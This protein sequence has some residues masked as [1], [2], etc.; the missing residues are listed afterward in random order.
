M[1]SV[2]LLTVRTSCLKHICWHFVLILE[3]EDPFSVSSHSGEASCNWC[4]HPGITEG[5]GSNARKFPIL[6][7]EPAART[8]QQ[9]IR[10]GRAVVDLLGRQKDPHING[11]TGI[12]PL[13][14]C[15]K[16]NIVDGMILDSLHWA[17]FGIGRR[18]MKLWLGETKK[19]K[20]KEN[21][22]AR[23]NVQ[24]P[25]YYVGTD[26]TKAVIDR[27][28]VNF[29][30]P[31]E[32]RRMPRELSQLH[33]FNAREFENIILYFSV[34]MF[35]GILPE[36]YMKHWILFVQAFYLL[37]KDKVTKDEVEVARE[38]LKRYVSKIG[39]LYGETEL[40]FN[41]HITLHA[42]DNTLRWSSFW[43]IS[44]FA[45]ENGNK[46]IKTKIHGERGIP[47]QVIRSLNRDSA[48]G[49]LRNVASTPQTSRFRRRMKRKEISKSFYAGTV[50]CVRPTRFDPTEDEQWLCD[51]KGID[52]AEY[53]QCKKIIVN[54]ICYS[55][56]DNKKTDNCVAYCSDGKI[57]KIKKI[58]ASER[59]EKV[60]LFVSRVRC[61]PYL[62][63]NVQSRLQFSP[64][65]Y[66]VDLIEE[67]VKVIAH[68]VLETICVNSNV[69]CQFLRDSF[70]SIM[71]NTVN[72]F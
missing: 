68:D 66:T 27:R 21:Q 16:F 23:G 6:P 14:R 56:S 20:K 55:A 69:D 3:Q 57:V 10:D 7:V 36:P 38:L 31:L 34:P 43:C 72:T 62:I 2:S 64:F 35:K 47:H 60:F 4:L 61:S 51:Q 49:V 65:M 28:I 50:N 22:A 63:P 53:T 52:V 32:V 13:V 54:E 1:A 70:V 12:S 45:F 25:A 71:P 11:V 42:A 29:H 48:L 41:M 18:M 37:M 44:T 46:I 30:P 33:T 15:P 67:E 24:M 39:E 59:L 40:N 58:I 5:G 19:K 26:E 9:M 17:A 8:H